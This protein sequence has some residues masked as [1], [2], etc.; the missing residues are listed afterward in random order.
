MHMFEKL[1]K[2]EVFIGVFAMLIIATMVFIGLSLYDENITTLDDFTA[3][4]TNSTPLENFDAI[5]MSSYSL[6]SNN[7]FLNGK[8]QA[9]QLRPQ[10]G[11]YCVHDEKN[12][13][14]IAPKIK[15]Y[16]Q[17]ERTDENVHF[18]IYSESINDSKKQILYE[19]SQYIIPDRGYLD[20]KRSGQWYSVSASDRY[21]AISIERNSIERILDPENRKGGLFVWE[22]DSLNRLYVDDN[23]VSD[24]LFI[25]NDYLIN[26]CSQSNSTMSIVNLISQTVFEQDISLN[27]TPI[28]V[29]DG[30]DIFFIDEET[31]ATFRLNTDFTSFAA[32]DSVENNI[33][34]PSEIRRV[35]VDQGDIDSPLTTIQYLTYDD[36]MN[37]VLLDDPKSKSIFYGV[38]A[39]QK[40]R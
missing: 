28:I 29:S 38:D 21:L 39:F 12:L 34:T 36:S 24:Q 26:C 6:G 9:L 37:W 32:L 40:I 20:F 13:V 14:F 4:C 15:V 33:Q 1:V 16:A 18:K 22:V 35:L 23:F 25:F 8:N 11:Y 27:F 17:E 5:D 3:E 31:N 19:A 2:K 10:T 30:D 7:F